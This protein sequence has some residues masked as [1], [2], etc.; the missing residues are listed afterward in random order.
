[1]CEPTTLSL[2]SLALGVG[3]QLAGDAAQ[4]RAS[5]STKKAALDSL[6]LTYE[7]IN[8]RETQTRAGAATETQQAVRTGMSA[9][10]E[11]R[12]SAAEAGVGGQSVAALI[13]TQEAQV[14]AYKDSVQENLTNNLAALDAE[15][16]G[17]SAQA[18]ARIAAVQPPSLIA[19]LLG[20]GGAGLSF[21]SQ[22]QAQKPALDPK[23]KA[24]LQP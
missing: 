16:S 24:T 9:A 22:R 5:A 17:A 4:T 23:I 21:F 7:D 3:G 14:G 15:R 18:D 2:A 10:G 19:T 6:R 13:D 20:L 8:Q 11:A 1:M 12:L